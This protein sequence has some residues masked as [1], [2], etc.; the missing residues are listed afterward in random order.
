MSTCRGCWNDWRVPLLP[1]MV[2]MEVASCDDD[3]LVQHAANEAQCQRQD[4][5]PHRMSECSMFEP[6]FIETNALGQQFGSR[7]ES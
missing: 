3:P 6:T 2:T 7:F 1:G 5:T 4:E